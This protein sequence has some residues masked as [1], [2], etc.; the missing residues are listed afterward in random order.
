MNFRAWQ[1]FAFRGLVAR[2][3][4]FGILAGL[5]PKV[6]L[7]KLSIELIQ[8]VSSGKIAFDAFGEH[9]IGE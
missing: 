4:S 2:V 9:R 1:D 8:V 7:S 3:H 6:T 5:R